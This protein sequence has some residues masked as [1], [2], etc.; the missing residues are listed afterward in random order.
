MNTHTLSLATSP[1]PGCVAI[2]DSQSGERAET[3]APLS[4]LRKYL[5]KAGPDWRPLD[6]CAFAERA[7]RANRQVTDWNDKTNRR[8]VQRDLFAA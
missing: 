4:M 1:V 6:V 5:E 3:R 8:P 7:S 2:I